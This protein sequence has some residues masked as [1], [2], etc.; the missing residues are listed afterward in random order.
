MDVTITL[1]ADEEAALTAQ[2]PLQDGET[3]PQSFQRIFR[4]EALRPIVERYQREQRELKAQLLLASWDVL[5]PAHQVEVETFTRGK[6]AAQL[7]KEAT[8]IDL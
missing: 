4:H 2:V 3:R 7:T 5:T 8:K 1:S 6:I